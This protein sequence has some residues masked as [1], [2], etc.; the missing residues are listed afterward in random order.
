[1]FK[2][3]ITLMMVFAIFTVNAHAVTKN[4]LKAEIGRAHV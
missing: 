1:M 4:G 2:K 3:L